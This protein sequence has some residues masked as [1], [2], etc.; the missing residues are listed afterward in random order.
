ML[1]RCRY[2]EEL[3]GFVENAVHVTHGCMHLHLIYDHDGEN[4]MQ[5]TV[6]TIHNFMRQASIRPEML[7]IRLHHIPLQ[8]EA[9]T[10]S[11]AYM[12]MVQACQC[13]RDAARR[14]A[15][16]PCDL[17][18][19]K[20]ILHLILED[21]DAVLVL[22]MDLYF[23]VDL[24]ELWE[25]FALFD[26]EQIIG[27][28]KEMQPSYLERLPK[29]ISSVR[30]RKL[31]KSSELH[32]VPAAHGDASGDSGSKFYGFNGGVQLLNL[33]RMR[34]SKSYAQAID[35]SFVTA[36]LKSWKGYRLYYGYQ[37]FYTMLFILYPQLFFALEC[38]WNRQLCGGVAAE[39]SSNISRAFADELFRCPSEESLGTAIYH[40]NCRNVLWW[41]PYEHICLSRQSVPLLSLD[42]ARQLTTNDTAVY[43]RNTKLWHKLCDNSMNVTRD[44]RT[45]RLLRSDYKENQSDRRLPLQGEEGTSNDFNRDEGSRD[46]NGDKMLITIRSALSKQSIVGG[47]S[48]G[49]H[50]GDI[51][52]LLGILSAPRR[53][54]ERESQRNSWLQDLQCYPDTGDARICWEYVFL[55]GQENS[56]N[57]VTRNLGVEA[58]QEEQKLNN[59]LLILDVNDSVA[60]LDIKV[61]QFFE[62]LASDEARPDLVLKTDDDSYIDLERFTNV[63]LGRPLFGLYGGHLVKRVK[64]YPVGHKWHVSDKDYQLIRKVKYMRGDAYLVSIDLVV[65]IA[66]AIAEG[67]VVRPFTEYGM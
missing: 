12:D 58:L 22:D 15:S 43:R 9:T 57:E 33:T 13:S 23:K 17:Y 4:S 42:V 31:V 29:F 3:L 55:I 52:I 1:Q 2:R 45:S 24:T 56:P 19:I 65:F 30:E 38:R 16:V 53:F 37:W 36:M 44:Y 41:P 11:H 14:K 18:L 46:F 59:D 32:E 35:G 64:H 20:P 61:M 63:L 49:Q 40:G 21:V 62:Q 25:Q 60:N 54:A 7:L 27:L 48:I 6:Q 47:S 34:E 67:R 39:A 10:A 5:I 66:Q 51:M 28:A 26:S 8:A 50:E